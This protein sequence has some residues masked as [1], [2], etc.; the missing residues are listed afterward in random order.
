[1][2]RLRYTDKTQSSGREI[3]SKGA[4]EKKIG[5]CQLSLL[6][7]PGV[8]LGN[9]SQEQCLNAEAFRNIKGRQAWGHPGWP[10]CSESTGNYVSHL[11]CHSVDSY[12]IYEM[13]CHVLRHT[14][15]TPMTFSF[16]VSCGSC[17]FCRSLFLLAVSPGTLPWF[18]VVF[19][20]FT[21]S[22]VQA[23]VDA[24]YG[25]SHVSPVS[26]AQWA[27]PQFENICTDFLSPILQ[28]EPTGPGHI[29]QRPASKKKGNAHCLVFSEEIS[30]HHWILFASLTCIKP[31]PN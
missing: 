11:S 3:V 8:I 16:F 29:D 31:R 12:C 24:M 18:V 25:S 4:R 13:S 6:G 1:M 7:R 26:L 14:T 23:H 9:P 19:V 2:R 20:F 5:H 27:S 22:M 28:D 10:V 17:W 21:R 15:D 30:F